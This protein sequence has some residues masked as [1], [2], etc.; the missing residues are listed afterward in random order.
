MNRGRG[1]PRQFDEDEAVM[2][3]MVVFWRKGLA[4]TSLEELAAAMQMNRPSIYNAFG[5]KEAIYR[6]ALARFCGQLD[7]AVTA[8]F[9]EQTPVHDAFS[10]FFTQAIEVYCGGSPAMGCLMI[11]TA[12]AEALMHAEIGKDLGGLIERLDEAFTLRLEQAHDA[13]EVAPT[14]AP[15][16]A[17][18]LLQATL[19]TLALRARSGASAESLKTL[20]AYAVASLLPRPV[21][22]IPS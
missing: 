15:K 11:C 7:V 17:G 6:H 18:Q 9:D 5:N 20:A 22:S 8:L 2:A 1:R 13:R 12:P 3:A 21:T 10:T 19:Q 4:A 16:L 14:V